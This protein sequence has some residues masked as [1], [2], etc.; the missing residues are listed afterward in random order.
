MSNVITPREGEEILLTVRK[1]M[2]RFL[3]QIFRFLLLFIPAVAL[4]VLYNNQIVVIFASLLLILSLTY[5]FYN[6]VI[7]YYDIYIITNKRVIA[8]SQKGLLNRE[9]AE[10]EASHISDVRYKI[11]GLIATLF[12]HGRVTVETKNGHTLE[13]DNLADPNEI[14]EMIKALADA[15]KKHEV[16]NKMSAD[17]FL[18]KI[19][20][21]KNNVAK[22]LNKK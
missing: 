19:L 22:T 14:Q 10:V 13:M 16:G 7:W 2:T 18:E 17:E 9:Y 21:S 3:K 6:F 5:A 1:S 20:L 8:V 4:L 12:Q 15:T 11:T